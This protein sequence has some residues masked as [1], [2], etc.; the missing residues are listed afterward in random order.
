MESWQAVSGRGVSHS[1]SHSHKHTHVSV[2]FVC[3]LG[4]LIART[5][6]C[7]EETMTSMSSLKRLSSWDKNTPRDIM[8]SPTILKLSGCAW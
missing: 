6:D 2:Q 5:S 3:L 8:A 7:K 4:T 1:H